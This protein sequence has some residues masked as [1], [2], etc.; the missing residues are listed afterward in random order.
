MKFLAKTLLATVTILTITSCGGWS[1]KDEKQF[2]EVCDKQNIVR[3]QC[4]C[5]ME[6]SKVEFDN[7]DAIKDDQA[8]FANIFLDAD[9][10]EKGKEQVEEN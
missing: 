9:C 7:F 3:A 1:E 5:M 6:K 8:K 2:H 10:L 4:D